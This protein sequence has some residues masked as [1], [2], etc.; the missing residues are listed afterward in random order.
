MLLPGSVPSDS[1]D[2]PRGW[3]PR[4]ARAL[5]RRKGPVLVIAQTLFSKIAEKD[6]NAMAERWKKHVDGILIFVNL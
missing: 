4:P 6:D 3:P 1:T 2:V 5:R